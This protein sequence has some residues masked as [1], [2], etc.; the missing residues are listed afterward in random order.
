MSRLGM[1]ENILVRQLHLLRRALEELALESSGEEG[2]QREDVL[3]SGE[4]TLL[5]THDQSDD[6]AGQ[7]TASYLS[8]SSMPTTGHVTPLTSR[9]A[10]YPCSA[11]TSSSHDRDTTS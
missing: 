8:A 7:G 10:D 1:Q 6:G 9:S 5:T 2:R 4:D 11:A 3:V